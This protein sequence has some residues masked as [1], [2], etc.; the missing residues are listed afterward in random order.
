[1]ASTLAS[2]WADIV[3]THAPHDIELYGT[4]LVQIL[5]FWLPSSI[6][7]AIDALFPTFSAR[8]K[9]QPPPK[10]PT[11]AEVRHCLRIALCNQLLA[12]GLALVPYY[13]TAVKG[14]PPSL[15]ITPAFPSLAEFA[16]HFV[17]C[18][19]L[20]EVLFYYAHRLLHSPVL[21]RAIHKM[22]HR[23]TAPVALASQYAH[24][25][26]HVVANALPLAIPP[27]LLGSHILTMW[28]FLAFML[29]ETCTVHSGFDF[30]GGLAW[31]HDEHHRRF[32]V[33][34]GGIG[35]LDWVHGTD[36]K[37]PKE[38]ERKGE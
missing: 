7:I 30:F 38:V 31:M 20:R 15:R 32:T 19:L 25:V 2:T 6:Y 34:F 36:A 4:L 8:H 18:C 28:A 33:N 27:V 11:A 37:R 24:P 35:L 10:Q 3:H 14:L 23:F 17:A 16:T 22:H 26:E 9:L 29:L 12:I 21:Y 5:F 1:M 13:L